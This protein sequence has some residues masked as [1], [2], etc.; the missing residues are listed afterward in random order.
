MKCPGEKR[1]NALVVLV[2]SDW[3]DIV[4]NTPSVE[5]ERVF[6]SALGDVKDMDDFQREFRE[7]VPLCDVCGVAYSQY[8][9][10]ELEE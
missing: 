2:D 4:R 7:H 6:Y 8:V 3:R 10:L 9:I 1:A 5:G